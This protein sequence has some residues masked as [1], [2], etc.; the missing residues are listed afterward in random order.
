MIEIGF[1]EIS[2]RAPWPAEAGEKAV[3]ENALTADHTEEPVEAHLNHASPRPETIRFQGIRMGYF[4]VDSYSKDG[5]I[6]L[7]RTVTLK[8][9]AGKT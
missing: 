7:N 8:E 9:D 1:E 6:V 4:C 5:S 2:S 3:N